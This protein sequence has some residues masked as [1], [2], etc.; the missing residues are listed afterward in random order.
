[1]MYYFQKISTL[2]TVF[3]S[4]LETGAIS[5]Y[6]IGQ[7]LSYGSIFFQVV[8]CACL[9]P[10]LFHATATTE[11]NIDGALGMG[12]KTFK[13]FIVLTLL[14][15][16]AVVGCQYLFGQMIFEVVDGATV[17]EV[18]KTLN[19]D[20]IIM[21]GVAFVMSIVELIMRNMP[22]HGKYYGEN[23]NVRTEKRGQRNEC[24]STNNPAVVVHIYNN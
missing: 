18:V 10:L 6:I 12:M 24:V 14:T 8:A 20:A 5:K 13:I 21:A 11:Y 15:M 1:M 4:L 7:Y 23:G 19:I 17:N 3:P 22:G 9:I 2:H 16:G